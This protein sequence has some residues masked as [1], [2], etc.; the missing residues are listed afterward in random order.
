MFAA[1]RVF[2]Q[3]DGSSPLSPH[4]CSGGGIS[5]LFIATNKLNQDQLALI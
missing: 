4:A 1:L 2:R 5:K 3:I